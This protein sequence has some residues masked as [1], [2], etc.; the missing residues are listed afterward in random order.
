MPLVSFVVPTYNRRELLRDRSLPSLLGQTHTDIEVLVV[1]DG[2]DRG[3]CDDVAVLASEDPRVQF[4]NLPHA[5]Y[6]SDT[7]ERWQVLGLEAL[8][9]GLDQA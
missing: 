6:P 5:E 1:G 3:T 8:N 4:W 9:F 7:V 2:T